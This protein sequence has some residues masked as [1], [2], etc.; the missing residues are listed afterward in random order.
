MVKP[1][2]IDPE[3]QNTIQPQRGPDIAGEFSGL[4]SALGMPYQA[5][6]QAAEKLGDIGDTMLKPEM[7]SKGAQAVTRDPTTGQLSVQLRTPLNDLDL[8]YNHAAASAFAAQSSGDR[9]LALQQMAQD[10]VDDPDKFRVLATQYIKTQAGG[11]GVPSELR[12]DILNDGLQDVTQFTTGLVA[13]KQKRDVQN[14]LTS[15]N[16]AIGNS[17]ND[18]YALAHDG[19]TDTPDFQIAWGKLQNQLVQKR[20][21]LFGVTQEQ[22]DQ[23][24]SETLS[25]ARGEA[26]I[27]AALNEAKAN[28]A[29]SGVE[30]ADKALWSPSLNLSPAQRSTFS[31]RAKTEIG[32][33][34]ATQR[35]ASTQL[36]QVVESRLDDAAATASITGRWDTIVSP[37]EIANAYKDNPSKGADIISALNAKAQGYSYSK[38][39]ANATPATIAAMD[40]Q[41]NPAANLS[42]KTGFDAFYSD[43]L[44]KV[45]GGYTPSDGNGSPA[46]FGINQGANPDIDVKNLTR[47]Q[48]KQILRDRYWT[49]SGAGQLPPA[50]AAVQGDT[51]VNMGVGTAKDLLQQ[52]GGDV[53]K[54]LSLREAR[55]RQIAAD[56]PAKKA[57]LPV[58]L[59]RNEDLRN[60]A[61]GGNMADEARTYT[62]FRQAVDERNKDL[63]KDPATYVIQN[64]PDIAANLQS[65]DPIQFQ[66][67]VRSL[68]QA[69]RDIGVQAPRILGT[70]QSAQIVQAFST[71]TDPNR[72]ADHMNQTIDGLAQQYGDYFPQVMKELQAKGMPPEAAALYQVRG[73]G[74]VAVRMATAI[75]S[76]AHMGKDINSG[77]DAYFNG[78]PNNSEIRKALPGAFGDYA[79]TFVGSPDGPQQMQSFNYAAGVYARQLA[80]EGITDPNQA[81]RKA[82]DDLVGSRYNLVDNYRVP[83]GIDQAA[84]QAGAN[85][86]KG[87]LLPGNME[88]YGSAAPGVSDDDRRGMTAKILSGQG[89]WVTRSDDKGLSLVWPQQSGYLPAIDAKGKPLTFSWA[90]LAAASQ[91]APAKTFGQEAAGAMH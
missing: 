58:W 42:P 52:S 33:W 1:I 79:Q 36:K 51:A 20:N 14:N 80:Y 43:Y 26:T 17:K 44:S 69:Q 5:L 18:I 78:A 81:A 4:S 68:Q 67:G 87:G 54:Y 39:V 64:R 31:N 28:G 75:N 49:A 27:G 74:T 55:Y 71:P 83:R 13:A 23:E 15:I 45:E 35:D 91:K 32:E 24:A 11:S 72:T 6:G 62:I 2:V 76:M 16:D 90:A 40:A 22:I 41:L 21:P 8:A 38:Q 77:R 30:F 47:D 70:Q 73:M 50:L 65:K 29:A 7:E 56:N 89:M 86:V 25:N 3:G 61:T 10:N 85:A 53:Q 88:P 63:A 19:G 34:A 84:V 48:A 9:R 66:M 82:H 46:N 57:D 12:G 37:N 60:F 59:Q